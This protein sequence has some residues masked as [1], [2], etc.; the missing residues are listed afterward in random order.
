[1]SQVLKINGTTI[2][3]QKSNLKKLPYQ[4]EI[5]DNRYTADGD[6]LSLNCTLEQIEAL[7]QALIAFANTQK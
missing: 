2:V 1:M 4:I 6:S 7:G 3:L 5:S